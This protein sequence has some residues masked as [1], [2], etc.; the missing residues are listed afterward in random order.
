MG[1]GEAANVT[2]GAGA[3]T[4]ANALKKDSDVWSHKAFLAKHIA[5]P[6]AFAK[7]ESMSEE[8]GC[9]PF[10]NLAKPF[11]NLKK[12]SDVWS[13]KSLYK[14]GEHPESWDAIKALIDSGDK[15]AITSVQ[16]NSDGWVKVTDPKIKEYGFT[17]RSAG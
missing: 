15:T 11:A 7:Y 16:K 3:A 17:P 5:K 1:T 8:D 4:K 9:K 10:A 14:P 12:D 2:A 6:L 13:H